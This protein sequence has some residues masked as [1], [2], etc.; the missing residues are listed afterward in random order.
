MKVLL[1]NPSADVK[2]TLGR[3]RKLMEPMPCIGLAYI[4]AVLEKNNIDVQ[5]I[6][7]FAEN[8]GVYGILD[9]IRSY[10]PDIVGISCLTPSAYVSY[11]LSGEIRKHDKNIKIIY[12]NLHAEIFSTSILEQDLADIIVRGE[13]EY[14]FLEIV[15]AIKKG[16]SLSKIKGISYKE[17]SQIIVNESR[18]LISNL[19]ELPYPAWH[20]FPHEKYGALPFADIKKPVVGMLASRG[21]PYNCKFCSKGYLKNTYRQ[22]SPKNIAD[23]IEFMIERFNAKQIA[24]MDLIF[25]LTKK[26]GIDFCDELIDRGLDRKIVWTCESRVDRV[27]EELLRKMKE[28]NCGRMMYGIESGVQELLD[29][30]NKG[31]TLEQVR[32][33]VKI[34]RR[35]G[36]KTVGFFMLGLPGE[37]QELSK[38]TI[39]FAK[40]LGLDFAKFAITTPFP[41]SPLFDMA[42][43]EGKIKLENIEGNDWE[44]FSAFNFNPDELLYV[45]DGMNAKELV[46][47]HK[48]ANREFYFRPSVIFNQLFNVRNV[49]IRQ[50][51]DGAIA[52]YLE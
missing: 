8:L 41:G 13:G 39:D 32:T 51:I 14:S 31:F 33:A 26:H 49:S 29:N 34:S 11:I 10:K 17:N 22:R 24:F 9:R 50:M 4:A 46:E 18:P 43:K 19:D 38:R 47:L 25:P 23:E 27:D 3:F 12:G 48:K 20:L 1:I 40:N 35:V 15:R 16:N 2:R 30:I 28:A 37:T 6:D 52:S 36:L 7:D 44:K 45:P 42:I 5:V 21:C